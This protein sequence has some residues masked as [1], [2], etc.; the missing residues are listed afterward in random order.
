[1]GPA[2]EPGQAPRAEDGGARHWEGKE[3]LLG[4]LMGALSYR[5]RRLVLQAARI[6]ERSSWRRQPRQRAVSHA[7]SVRVLHR[8]ASTT[9]STEPIPYFAGCI[10]CQFTF[11]CL[12]GSKLGSLLSW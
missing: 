5:P 10:C 9:S 1:M 2:A 6:S 12:L 11:E 8:D 4:L 3:T 7:P